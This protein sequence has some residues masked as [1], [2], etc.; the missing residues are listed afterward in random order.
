MRIPKRIEGVF[1]HQ[2][3]CISAFYKAHCCRNSRA[4]AVCLLREIPNELRRNLGVG[5]G[6]KGNISSCQLFSQVIKI[7]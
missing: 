6:A 2:H 1:S 7:D 4:K 5:V 3:H